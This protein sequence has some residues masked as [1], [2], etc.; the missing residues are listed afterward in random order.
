MEWVTA[1]CVWMIKIG[2]LGPE[3]W[4]FCYADFY[5]ISIYSIILTELN[6]FIPKFPIHELLSWYLYHRWT[7]KWHLSSINYLCILSVCQMTTSNALLTDFTWL[8]FFLH[9]K[10]NIESHAKNIY[11]TFVSLSKFVCHSWFVFIRGLILARILFPTTE[12]KEV[13]FQ[14]CGFTVRFHH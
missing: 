5:S 2:S 6:I 7:Q 1:L 13:K 14:S 11:N 8:G 4:A 10:W 3:Q 9:C 12:K